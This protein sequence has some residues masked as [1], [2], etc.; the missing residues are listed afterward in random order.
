MLFDFAIFILSFNRCLMFAPPCFST[1]GGRKTV[2]HHLH[3]TSKVFLRLW[4]ALK[5]IPRELK[6]EVRKEY[7]VRQSHV[8]SILATREHDF[9]MFDSS[10][11]L[12][13][14][15]KVSGYDG[16]CRHSYQQSHIQ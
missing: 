15:A 5:L 4:R 12:P 11:N 13:G 10:L 8:P 2:G 14:E 3:L 6:D 7:S 9:Q 1:T 16:V